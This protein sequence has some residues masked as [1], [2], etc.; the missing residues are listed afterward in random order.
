[1]VK[2][3]EKLDEAAKKAVHTLDKHYDGDVRAKLAL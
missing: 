1:M 3:H 2:L